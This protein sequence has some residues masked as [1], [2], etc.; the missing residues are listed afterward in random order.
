MKR[1]LIAAVAAAGLF[2]AVAAPAAS[3]DQGAPGSTFPEQPGVHVQTAC[4]AVTTNPGTG[5]NRLGDIIPPDTNA[6]LS[7]ILTDACTF[8]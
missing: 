7:G 5:N 3:A 2:A 8:D 6:L 1:R 4:G